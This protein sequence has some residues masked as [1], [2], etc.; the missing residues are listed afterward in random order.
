MPFVYALLILRLLPFAFVLLLPLLLPLLF[1]ACVRSPTAV[2]TA[3]AAVMLLLLLLLSLLCSRRREHELVAQPIAAAAAAAAFPAAMTP[4]AYIP[5]ADFVV[6]AD[7]VRVVAVVRGFESVPP[8]AAAPAGVYVV[9]G[10]VVAVLACCRPS[11]LNTRHKPGI[12]TRF[13]FLFVSHPIDDLRTSSSL[14]PSNS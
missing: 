5:D 14:S 1:T 4:R 3:A 11:A 9:V 6:Y 8:A 13:F 10:V 2:P 7:V 12:H